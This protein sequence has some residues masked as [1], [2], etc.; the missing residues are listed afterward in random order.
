MHS[1]NHKK[2]IYF[3]SFILFFFFYFYFFKYIYA[4]KWN[5]WIHEK[6]PRF[7]V[8]LCTGASLA[9]SGAV[10]QSLFQNPLASPSVLGISSGG[11]L[12]VIIIYAMNWHLLYP[13]LVPLSAIVGVLTTLLLVYNLSKSKGTIHLNN[14]ILTGVAISI[15]MMAFQSFVIYFF[16]NNWHLMQIIAEWESGSTLDRTWDHV[17]M[18]LP[19]TLFG[20]SGCLKYRRELDVLALGYEEAINLG[21]D[22]K[23][24]QKKLF[25]CISLLIGGSLAAVGS[26][27]FFGL[28]LPHLFRI[29]FGP[30]NRLLV[31]LSIF[32]GAIVFS[33]MDLFLRFFEIHNFTLGNVSAIIGG[34]FF[35]ILLL[36][37]K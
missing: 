2:F 37:S 36:K 16:R 29:I 24:I 10:T 14:V 8:T 6:I 26:I 33:T 27:A 25:F 3:I 5:P 12:F 30:S 22:V 11:S 19:L 20:I 4:A 18:Q 7:I 34:L 32:G 23:K 9:V 1:K 17:N 28:V 31:P 15:L 21:I 13:F 35:L